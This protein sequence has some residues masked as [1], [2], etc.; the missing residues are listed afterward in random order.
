MGTEVNWLGVLLA[1]I[2]S[3]VIGFIYYMPKVFGDRW[4]RL[5]KID[6]KLFKKEQPRLM[7]L[8]FVAALLTAFVLAHFIT[9]VHNY[10]GNSW[11]AAGV[12]T[13][14]WTWAGF[15]LTTLFVHDSLDQKSFNVT[16]IS[17][18]NRLLS[19]LAMGLILGWLH[20]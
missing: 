6:D 17:W 19:F 10:F 13:A 16:I 12:G 4:M 11:M 14:L 1:G 15:S 18:G 8:L 3:M 7:P 9:I 20:P 2:S 5:G